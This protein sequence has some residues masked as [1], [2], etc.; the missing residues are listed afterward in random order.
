MTK[1][2]LYRIFI[3]I[4]KLG[5]KSSKNRNEFGENMLLNDNNLFNKIKY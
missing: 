4:Y 5:K 2:L 3:D 1:L